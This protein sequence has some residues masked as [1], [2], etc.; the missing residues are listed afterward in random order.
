MDYDEHSPD[1]FIGA[2]LVTLIVI[3]LGAIAIALYKATLN[4]EGR[5]IL[6][7]F[8]SLILL[9]LVIYGFIKI[10]KNIKNKPKSDRLLKIKNRHMPRIFRYAIYSALTVLIWRFV[11]N[12]DQIVNFFVSLLVK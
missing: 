12:I 3:F 7:F 1:D 11:N 5:E 9:F 8:G 10:V 2:I 4:S 6:M